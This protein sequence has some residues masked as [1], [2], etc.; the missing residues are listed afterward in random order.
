MIGVALFL[1]IVG[2]TMLLGVLR[3]V[4][5]EGEVDADWLVVAALLVGAGAF[6]TTL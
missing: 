3:T 6:F 5:V 1:I 4:I 2:A